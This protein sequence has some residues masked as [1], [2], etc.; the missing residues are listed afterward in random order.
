MMVQV[1]A[2]HS[3]LSAGEI[4]NIFSRNTDEYFSAEEVLEMGLVDKII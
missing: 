3:K 4:F 1:L 2:E